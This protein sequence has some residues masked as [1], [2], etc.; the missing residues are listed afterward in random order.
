[1]AIIKPELMY[2]RTHEWVKE[3]EGGYLVGITDFAQSALGAIVF[4]D[5]PD[6]GADINRGDELLTLESVKSVS[7][8]Y[9]PIDGVAVRYNMELDARPELINEDAYEAWLV[10][11]ATDHAELSGLMD[12]GEYEAY[13][14]EAEGVN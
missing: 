14:A 13:C 5:M 6:A 2:T 8:V 11:L 3:A 9:S 7:P 10:M 4:V 12:A 1:M